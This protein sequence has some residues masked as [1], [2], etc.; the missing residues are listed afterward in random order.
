M[1][2][3]AVACSRVQMQVKTCNCMLPDMNACTTCTEKQLRA[4][5]CRMQLHAS[6]CSTKQ[7]GSAKCSYA[8]RFIHMNP[9]AAKTLSPSPTTHLPWCARTTSVSH[10]E[11]VGMFSAITGSRC[12][13]VYVFRTNWF[14]EVL[15]ENWSDV[16]LYCY[17]CR[18]S[19]AYL[20]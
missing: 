15:N 4:H 8:S 18:C 20:A 9:D 5:M 12:A 2:A 7:A 17:F 6:L 19:L 10:V 3:H 16:S 13:S 14:C 1:R 11:H